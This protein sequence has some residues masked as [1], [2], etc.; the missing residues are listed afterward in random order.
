M[1]LIALSGWGQYADKARALEAGFDFHFVKPLDID[2]LLRCLQQI[3][4]D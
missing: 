4:D 1:S 2:E 3:G